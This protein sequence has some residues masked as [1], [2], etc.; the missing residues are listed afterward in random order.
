M[1]LVEVRV[2]PSLGDNSDESAAQ[3]YLVLKDTSEDD[4][5]QSTVERVQTHDV[6]VT[7]ALDELIRPEPPLLRPLLIV[8]EKPTKGIAVASETVVAV[9]PEV[10]QGACRVRDAEASTDQEIQQL[11]I[12]A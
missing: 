3:A 5:P 9:S 11:L 2:R 6:V 12:A 4:L 10:L 7:C 8:G 1:R